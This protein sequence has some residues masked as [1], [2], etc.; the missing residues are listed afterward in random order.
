[1]A[2]DVTPIDEFVGPPAPAAIHAAAPAAELSALDAL[3]AA[4]AASGKKMSVSVVLEGAQ[5]EKP[6][7]GGRWL[8]ILAYNHLARTMGASGCS[9]RQMATAASVPSWYTSGCCLLWLAAA[10]SREVFQA[11]D[12]IQASFPELPVSAQ[13]IRDRKTYRD[14]AAVGA[15]VLEGKSPARAEIQL[16][17]QS[18]FTF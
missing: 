16:L 3:N 4:L 13:F 12:A 14:A 6:P 2:I 7:F 18:V 9:A 11:R 15:S 8:K 17:A 5:Q 10:G 1:M